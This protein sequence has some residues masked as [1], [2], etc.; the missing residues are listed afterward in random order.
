[1]ASLDVSAVSILGE[2]GIRY[3]RNT[4][5]A[6]LIATVLYWT[7]APLGDVSLFGVSLSNVQDKEAAAW[8][9]FFVILIY[10]WI[11]LT[12]YGW[13]DWRIW[14]QRVRETFSLLVRNAAFWIGK[15]TVAWEGGLPTEWIIS[16]TVNN[17]RQIHW[18]ARRSGGAK[19][20]GSMLYTDREYV[21]WRL[22][23]FLTIE[24]GLAFLWGLACL[25][26][27]LSKIL[28]WPYLLSSVIWTGSGIS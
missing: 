21:R 2:R 1:M 3:K 4:L 12:Y 26:L 20:S 22:L 6:S 10:Q 7:K 23:A 13:T 5:A 11:M 19:R 17:H 14:Q 18:T 15:G 25:Y 27:A 8:I 9:I 16:H 28:S 24:F